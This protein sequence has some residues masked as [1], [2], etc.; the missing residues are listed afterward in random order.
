MHLF[1][2]LCYRALKVKNEHF[3]TTNVKGYCCHLHIIFSYNLLFKT[4]INFKKLIF[5]AKEWHSQYNVYLLQHVITAYT[6]KVLHCT[7]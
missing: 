4:S 6:R 5:L 3:I 2:S 1:V 7:R